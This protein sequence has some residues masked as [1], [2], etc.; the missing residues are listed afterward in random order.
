MSLSERRFDNPVYE[1]R[2]ENE[3]G[4]ARILHH[5]LLLSC[6]TLPVAEPQQRPHREGTAQSERLLRR[7]QTYRQGS[8]EEWLEP[9]NES[10]DKIFEDQ[11]RW[12]TVE[13]LGFSDLNPDTTAFQPQRRVKRQPTPFPSPLTIQK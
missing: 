6:D 1:V 11:A 13:E 3:S 12:G 9:F 5:N 2:P 8:V 4:R 7:M 10:E